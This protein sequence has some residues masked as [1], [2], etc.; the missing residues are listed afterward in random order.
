MYIGTSIANFTCLVGVALSDQSLEGSGNLGVLKGAHR[1]MSEF[2]RW[3]RKNSNNEHPVV[4]GPEGP[5]WPREN[6]H[7]PNKHGLVHYPPVVRRKFKTQEVG[8]ICVLISLLSLTYHTN[9]SHRV[10]S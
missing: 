6:E 3:Q 7:A 9:I 10:L 8:L 2:F 5:G 4:L 1:H